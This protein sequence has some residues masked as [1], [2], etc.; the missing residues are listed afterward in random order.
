MLF[1][2]LLLWLNYIRCACECS[3]LLGSCLYSCVFTLL[4]VVIRHMRCLNE[5]LD[6]KI[7]MSSF[8]PGQINCIFHGFELVSPSSALLPRDAFM[9]LTHR[10]MPMIC[11]FVCIHIF[12]CS[13]CVYG[14]RNAVRTTTVRPVC[15]LW[16]TS[17]RYRFVHTIGVLYD[18]VSVTG[19]AK[20]RL[21]GVQCNSW[22]FGRGADALTNGQQ[23]YYIELHVARVGLMTG[24]RSNAM[25]DCGLVGTNSTSFSIS[26]LN[27]HKCEW[28]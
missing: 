25:R 24:H 28:V 19:A 14:S 10:M 21:S 23:L 13:E 9:K 3:V 8:M 16:M 7:E 27:G 22:Q 5:W 4:A 17:F 26:L 2:R 1:A 11:A 20:Q 15:L 12:Y 18:D 6:S